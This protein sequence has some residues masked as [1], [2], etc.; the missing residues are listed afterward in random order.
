VAQ[1]KNCPLGDN[2]TIQL[3][4]NYFSVVPLLQSVSDITRNSLIDLCTSHYSRPKIVSLYLHK[5]YPH[6]GE[7]GKN[8]DRKYM[9]KTRKKKKAN[10]KKY[11]W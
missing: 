8:E 10:E 5:N 11:A 6:V 4:N 3:K 7:E 9:I 1:L 2:T